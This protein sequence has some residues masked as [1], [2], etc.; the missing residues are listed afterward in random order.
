MMAISVSVELKVRSFYLWWN[1]YKWA[2]YAGNTCN[3]PYG[4]VCLAAPRTKHEAY[5][6]PY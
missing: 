4:Y 3:E 6:W 5:R 1:L 2:S